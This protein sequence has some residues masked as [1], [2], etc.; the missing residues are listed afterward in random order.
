MTRT[1]KSSVLWQNV[2]QDEVS[3]SVV[4][5]FASDREARVVGQEVIRARSWNS[6]S[7]LPLEIYW[8]LI[9]LSGNY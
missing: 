9:N 8:D 3:L 4:G 6:D 1:N 2:N 7:A 5:K